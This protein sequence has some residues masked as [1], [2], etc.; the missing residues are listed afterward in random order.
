MVLPHPPPHP[1]AVAREYVWWAND[2]DPFDIG[3][4]TATAFSLPYGQVQDHAAVVQVGGGVEGGS[5]GQREA[6]G[7]APMSLSLSPMHV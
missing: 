4:T 6:V 7:V 2:T 5:G 3:A 1:Q